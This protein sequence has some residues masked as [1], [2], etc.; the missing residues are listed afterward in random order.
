MV[1]VEQ[2]PHV[3][4][5]R[6]ASLDV[7]AFIEQRRNEVARGFPAIV[8]DRARAVHLEVL[9]AP[10]FG[11]ARISEDRVRIDPV[12]TLLIDPV[13]NGGHR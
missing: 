10:M 13:D 6:M 8:I 7:R 5:V 11:R 3:G 2:L 1:Q 4:F 12:D 9:G